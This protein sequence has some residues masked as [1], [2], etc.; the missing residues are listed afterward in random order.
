[1]SVCHQCCLYRGPDHGEVTLGQGFSAS[2]WIGFLVSCLFFTSAKHMDY[3]WN[4]DKDG[5]EVTCSKIPALGTELRPEEVGGSDPPDGYANS[6]TSDDVSLIAE[7]LS[8]CFRSSRVGGSSS[9]FWA[10]LTSS[11]SL[12]FCITHGFGAACKLSFLLTS[13]CIFDWSFLGAHI[14]ALILWCCLVL[15]SISVDLASMRN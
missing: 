11:G 15:I 2:Q 7:H 13:R 4:I 1:M 6:H 3:I 10:P 8:W 12:F 14:L 9:F 5:Y